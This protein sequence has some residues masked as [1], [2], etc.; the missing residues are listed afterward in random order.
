[1]ALTIVWR[2]PMPFIRTERALQRKTRSFD[3]I[4][5]ATDPYPL[6]DI[7]AVLG[8]VEHGLVPDT[9]DLSQNQR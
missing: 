3:T 4:H 5:A 8:A 2:N 9:T 7:D 6:T 1:M